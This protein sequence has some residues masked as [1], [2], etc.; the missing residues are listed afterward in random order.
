MPTFW[1]KSICSRVQLLITDGC[2]N[3]YLS[4]I[5]NIGLNGSFPNAVHGL[6]YFHLVIQGLKHYVYPTIP[7]IGNEYEGSM[8]T[9]I[10]VNYWIKQWFFDVE[11]IDEYNHS[12]NKFYIWL[13]KQKGD[14]LQFDILY[15]FEYY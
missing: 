12:R 3:E 7:K 13:D 5:S 11:D 9:M 14:I 8:K 4:F 15:I 1:G 2:T 6:C 10:I